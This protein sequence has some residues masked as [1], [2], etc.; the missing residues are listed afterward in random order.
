MNIDSIAFYTDHVLPF[1]VKFTTC[2]G[3]ITHT[4]LLRTI[5]SV[6]NRAALAG[7]R[8]R[9]ADGLVFPL[10]LQ[11]C[12]V[13]FP[14]LIFFPYQ[15]I[16][17]WPPFTT[18]YIN[19]YFPLYYFSSTLSWLSGNSPSQYLLNEA[20]ENSYLQITKKGQNTCAEL[21]FYVFTL[22]TAR[23]SWKFDS[24]I[25]RLCYSKPTNR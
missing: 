11:T 1:I 9:A 3:C 19:I 7:H 17:Q 5:L 12:L 16:L 13:F 14:A 20:G 22:L 2:I 15:H 18:Y 21:E 25:C 4:D 24:Q 23:S 8:S 10:L 6:W